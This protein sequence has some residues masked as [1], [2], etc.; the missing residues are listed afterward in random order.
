M[1]SALVVDVKRKIRFMSYGV[2][3]LRRMFGEVLLPVFIN[4]LGRAT[5]Q[6]FFQ[7]FER[8]RLKL[9]AVV[10]RGIRFR[11]N[12]WLHEGI[13]KHPNEVFRTT[14]SSL[15]DFKVLNTDPCAPVSPPSIVQV[16]SH[17]SWQPPHPGIIKLNWD[18]SINL[19]EGRMGMG[20]VARDC[21]GEILGARCMAQTIRV[22][23][24]MVEVMAALYEVLF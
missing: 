8:D 7:C 23:P 20:F 3:Q 22:E 4:V 16:M 6:Y 12:K 9:M 5:I 18:A 14:M 21:H 10:A 19:K 11:R 24:N 17:I 2:V 15:E 1:C 13:F